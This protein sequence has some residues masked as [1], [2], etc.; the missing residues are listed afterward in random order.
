LCPLEDQLDEVIAPAGVVCLDL[1]E[2]GTM[3]RRPGTGDVVQRIRMRMAGD[4]N[5]A[6]STNRCWPASCSL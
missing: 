3:S 4:R 5:L 2:E 1:R 6:A